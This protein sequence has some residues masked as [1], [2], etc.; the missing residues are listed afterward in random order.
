MLYKQIQYKSKP[1]QN[2]SLHL[3]ADGMGSE[4][5]LDA[6]P[7]FVYNR[8]PD[9]LSDY[10][11]QSHTWPTSQYQRNTIFKSNLWQHNT[12]Q[13]LVFLL[14]NQ[15]NFPLNINENKYTDTHIF[16]VILYLM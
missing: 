6:I 7:P 4:T 13:T 15:M 12:F 3:L 14:Q 10:N 1:T 8:M 5:F 11:T 2:L 9:L 16:V